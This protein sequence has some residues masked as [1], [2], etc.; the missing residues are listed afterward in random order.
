MSESGFKNLA[1]I[2]LAAGIGKRMN[3]PSRAKVMALLSGKPLIHHVLDKVV[4]LSPKE[5]Y[6]IVGHQMQSVVEYINSKNFDLIYVEQNEQLG[7]GHAVNQAESFLN[8]FDGEVLILCGDVPNLRASTLEKFISRHFNENSGIS[9]LSTCAPN[10]NGYG[11]II[12]DAEKE[13]LKIIEEKDAGDDEKKVNEINSGVY[14]AKAKILFPALKRIS[15]NNA[16]A[17]YY[18][19]DVIDILRT[20]GAVVKAFPSAEFDEVQGVNSPEDLKKAEEYF[21]KL[22]N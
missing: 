17:E 15:N 21:N 9:V 18:L 20:D 12:R 22:S 8:D 6:L 5:T 3:D 4:L 19:T 13:F 10:P 2:I 1:V 11:R 7:T 14:I 16:Q